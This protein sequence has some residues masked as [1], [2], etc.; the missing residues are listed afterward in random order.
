MLT[1]Q[2]EQSFTDHDWFQET[3]IIVIPG[4][5]SDNLQD[6]AGI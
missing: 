3:F 5:S 6:G 1:G 2:A 4:W